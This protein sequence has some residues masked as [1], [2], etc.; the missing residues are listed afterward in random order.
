MTCVDS[1]EARVGAIRAVDVVS[2]SC[3]EKNVPKPLC[4]SSGTS[5]GRRRAS[6]RANSK[7]TCPHG[8][9][10]SG[11]DTRIA[12]IR[13]DE[14]SLGHDARFGVRRRWVVLPLVCAVGACKVVRVRPLFVRHRRP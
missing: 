14:V 7:L 13:A 2:T 1:D 9:C 8:M 5:S 12:A 3:G 11:C 6:L 10:Y 4:R